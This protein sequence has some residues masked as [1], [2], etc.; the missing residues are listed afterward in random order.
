VTS[1]KRQPI[2]CLSIATFKFYIVSNLN[3]L[4]LLTFDRFGISYICHSPNVNF[5]QYPYVAVHH[6]VYASKQSSKD[7][8]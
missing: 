1:K 8:R 7:L 5:M 2:G 4:R 3:Y 6:L